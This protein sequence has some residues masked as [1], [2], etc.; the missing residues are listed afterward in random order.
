MSRL[1]RICFALMAML[2]FH[3]AV[4]AASTS[5]LPMNTMPLSKLVG[6]IEPIDLRGVRTIY[7]VFIPLSRRLDL[8]K[9]T[10]HLEYVNSI[11]LVGERSQLVVKLN[12]DVVA[13]LPLNLKL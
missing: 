5:A 9:V 2:A 13:Q 6:Q 10:L 4:E 8:N 7:P 3:P 11:A 1:L 12:E